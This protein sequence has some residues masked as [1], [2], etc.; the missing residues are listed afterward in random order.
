M[1]LVRPPRPSPRVSLVPLIDVLFILLVYFMVTSV[2]LDLDMIPASNTRD[3]PQDTPVPTASA[4]AVE[5]ARTLLLRIGGDGV[6]ILRGA[7]LAPEALRSTLAAEVAARPDLTVVILPSPVA[8]VQALATTLDALAQAGV[9]DTRLLR[10][11]A[12]P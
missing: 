3:D 1:T 9:Q 7:A 12:E 10:I 5:A 8:P 4:G 2:Y 11:E 6:A